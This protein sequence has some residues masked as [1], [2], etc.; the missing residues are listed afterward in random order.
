MMRP[1]ASTAQKVHE[2]VA[3]S[4]P[5]QSKRAAPV[6]AA[7]GKVRR[8]TISDEDK[9]N[10][11]RGGHPEDS[12]PPTTDTEQMEANGNAKVEPQP[13]NDITPAVEPESGAV[14]S[15]RDALEASSA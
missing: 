12:A 11:H 13:L 8:S 1:T 14:D 2:K 5:P 7:K 4:S 15:S 9:E 10:T 3:P 6:Q